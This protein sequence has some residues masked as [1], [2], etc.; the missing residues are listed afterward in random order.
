MNEHESYMRRCLELGRESMRLGN[1]PVGSLLVLNGQ[2][3]GE[4]LELGKSKNDIT[5]HA[6]IE[7]IRDA[8]KKLEVT[9]LTGAVLYTTHEPCL[10]CSYTIR[11]YEIAEVYFG[12]A[13]GEIGGHSSVY[14]LLDTNEISIWAKPPKVIS[15]VLASECQQLHDE[16]LD[17]KKKDQ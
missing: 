12:L 15:G 16:F 13:V 7:A 10:M 6:E 2:V 14:K 5:Y 1:A 3:I 11:H 9:K 8:L 4:G 17:Q